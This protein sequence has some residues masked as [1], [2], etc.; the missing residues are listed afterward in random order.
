MRREARRSHGR[1]SGCT[2]KSKVKVLRKVDTPRTQVAAKVRLKFA[3]TELVAMKIAYSE[4]TVQAEVLLLTQDCVSRTCPTKV[5]HV[6]KHERTGSVTS[7]E[8][9]ISVNPAIVL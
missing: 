7:G 6:P 9:W 3:S 8:R 1:S 5:P 2:W 4:S